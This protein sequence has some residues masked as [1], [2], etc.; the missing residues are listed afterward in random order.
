M[1]FVAWLFGVPGSGKSTV[2]ASV[3]ST[4]GPEIE[5]IDGDDFRSRVTPAPSWTIEERGI[6]YR[7]IAEAATRLHR[8]RISV[9]IAASGGGVDMDAV[10]QLLPEETLMIHV[11]CELEVALARRPRG[12][13]EQGL[14]AAIK[15]PIIRVDPTGQPWVADLAFSERYG[16]PWYELRLP[17]HVDLTVDTTSS[18][19]HSVAQQIIAELERRSTLGR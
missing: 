2:A 5:L 3:A 1:A 16:I 10:A 8:H 9:L 14:G 13:Y 19:V 12:V 17:T 11:V 6:V 7:A 15:L 18:D 4:I